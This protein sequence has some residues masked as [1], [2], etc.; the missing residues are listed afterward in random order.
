M[1]SYVMLFALPFIPQ[2]TTALAAPSFCPNCVECSASATASPIHSM[3]RPQSDSCLEE[4]PTVAAHS[5]NA[6]SGA[7][8]AVSSTNFSD[9]PPRFLELRFL[10]CEAACSVA[11]A[12][13]ICCRLAKRSRCAGWIELW[14]ASEN[15]KR[16]L[17]HACGEIAN[18][19]GIRFETTALQI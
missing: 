12:R 13:A 14:R 4:V 18:V 11:S 9:S 17:F 7:E 19:I 16:D 15:R 2:F 5:R 10:S 3:R 8:G 1:I 6:T